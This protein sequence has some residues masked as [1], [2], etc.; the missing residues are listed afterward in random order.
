MIISAP[1]RIARP[2]SAYLELGDVWSWTASPSRL[3]AGTLYVLADGA[4]TLRADPLGL[5]AL[6]DRLALT[7]PEAD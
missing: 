5:T 7:I 1:A 4:L 2:W 3:P 6:G